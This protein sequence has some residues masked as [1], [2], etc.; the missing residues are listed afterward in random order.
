MTLVDVGRWKKWS[1]DGQD[2]AGK[3]LDAVWEITM[4]SGRNVLR[5]GRQAAE[6]M[7]AFENLDAVC[8][9]ALNECGPVE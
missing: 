9:D 4:H 6:R 7:Q 3:K 2:A 1:G 5:R 8:M